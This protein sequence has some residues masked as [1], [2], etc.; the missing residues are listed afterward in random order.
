M[1][2]LTHQ[3]LAVP[4]QLPGQVLV[5]R[6][7]G[8]ADPPTLIPLASSTRDPRQ[9]RTLGPASTRVRCPIVLQFALHSS[10]DFH[11]RIL[12]A[13]SLK[14]WLFIYTTLYIVAVSSQGSAA[15]GNP[16]RCPTDRIGRITP[17][18]YLLS[19]VAAIMTSLLPTIPRLVFAVVE[20]ISL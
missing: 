18:P 5:P 17:A 16:K 4:G 11:I 14:L 2:T 13:L 7:A 10:C 19:N 9:P 3:P 8:S 12:R 15:P 6:S 20:P 1:G